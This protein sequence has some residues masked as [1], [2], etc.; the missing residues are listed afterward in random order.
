MKLG[1]PPPTFPEGLPGDEDDLAWAL[2]A[3]ASEWKRGARADALVWL[4]RAIEEA[5]QV[6]RKTRAR[7]L[8]YHL[9]TLEMALEAGWVAEPLEPEQDLVEIPVDP[10][11]ELSDDDDVIEFDDADVELLSS[12]SSEPPPV[13]EPA[14]TLP[15]A[16]MTLDQLATHAGSDPP[17]WGAQ[18]S[19][20]SGASELLK[21]LSRFDPPGT[22]VLRSPPPVRSGSVPPKPKRSPLSP[23]RSLPPAP[24][25]RI[26]S[27]TS[28]L[29]LPRF[30]SIP[31]EA[32]STR[33]EEILQPPSIAGIL[34]SSVIGLQD[35]PETTQ[36]RLAE[37][38]EVHVLTAEEGLEMFGMALV[39][40]GSVAVMPTVADVSA[41]EVERGEPIVM[42]GHLREGV[43]IRA[44]ACREGAQ[45]AV[46]TPAELQAAIDDSP[47]VGVEL[48]R[49]G[50]RLQALAGV[51]IGLLGEQL[52]D[53]LR[54]LVFGRC[55]VRHLN[56][57]ELIARAGSPL[58]GLVAL[59]A[60]RIE[61]STPGD[62][63]GDCLG[64]GDFLFPQEMLRAAPAPA[65]AIAGEGG[66][67]VLFAERRVAHE[68]MLSVPPLL[69]LFAS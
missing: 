33:A 47:E 59:G 42:L 60:G 15:E 18:E 54:A 53:V 23:P 19:N 13:R 44:V 41:V 14:L 17:H 63:S 28:S 12:D 55:E 69:G 1:H 62:E 26:A 31:P 38:A 37:Q 6:G 43:A 7:D 48:R 58:P 27:G 57:G 35:L 65:N 61:L 3:G 30:T 46:W 24:P 40:E 66:A 20:P 8:E 51:S 64:P 32:P 68:L 56:A 16:G 10:D 34:L 5:R 45:L 2:S 21:V 22:P 49:I 25:P 67:L 29:P 50:D 39:V 52:D 36:A 9:R 4:G 11:E